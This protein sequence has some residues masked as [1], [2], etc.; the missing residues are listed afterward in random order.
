MSFFGLT[1]LGSGNQFEN[2]K[3]PVVASFENVD[4][5][6]WES[7][8][9]HYALSGNEELCEELRVS[10]SLCLRGVQTCWAPG[11]HLVTQTAAEPHLKPTLAKLT[12]AHN[13]RVLLR[14]AAFGT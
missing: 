8:F 5:A 10:A 9:K 11:V 3:T 14:L 7:A 4:D 12:T 2:N 6:T 13:E 1:L